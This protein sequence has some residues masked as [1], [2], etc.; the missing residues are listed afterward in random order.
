[1]V[2]ALHNLPFPTP[3][4]KKEKIHFPLTKKEKRDIFFHFSE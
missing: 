2:A 3:L 1:M 4:S